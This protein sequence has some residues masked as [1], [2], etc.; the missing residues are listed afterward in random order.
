MVLRKN[1]TRRQQTKTKTID[2][3]GSFRQKRHRQHNNNRCQIQEC[4]PQARAVKSRSTSTP[5]TTT[6]ATADRVPPIP[7]LVQD[8]DSATRGQPN[9]SSAGP[10]TAR[11]LA[12]IDETITTKN[13]AY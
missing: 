7:R 6:A 8:L 4:H 1:P 9:E 10:Q 2:T 3:P 5:T 13:H 12:R 11:Y